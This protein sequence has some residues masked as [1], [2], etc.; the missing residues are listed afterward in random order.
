MTWTFVDSWY[1]PI[2]DKFRKH[3]EENHPD[4]YH[5]NQEEIEYAEESLHYDTRKDGEGQVWRCCWADCTWKIEWI[6]EYRLASLK[7]VKK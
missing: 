6:A 5:E 1:E 3:L 7:E 2:L 4:R